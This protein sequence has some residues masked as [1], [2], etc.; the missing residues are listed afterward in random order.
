MTP[1][2]VWGADRRGRLLVRADDGTDAIQKPRAGCEVLA[3]ASVVRTKSQP[4]LPL[5][6]VEQ[7]QA[8]DIRLVVG[9]GARTARC[10][11]VTR[12]D[13]PRQFRLIASAP[14]RLLT[15]PP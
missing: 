4:S 6:V 3:Q 13:W 1:G 2:V 9:L 14:T 5:D 11:P 7:H 8:I 10:R 15:P 12:R